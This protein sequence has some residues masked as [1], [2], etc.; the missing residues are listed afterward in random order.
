L[1]AVRMGWGWGQRVGWWGWVR[2]RGSVGMWVVAVDGR[3][4]NLCGCQHTSGRRCR[5]LSLGAVPAHLPRYASAVALDGAWVQFPRLQLLVPNLKP[6]ACLLPLRSTG[7]CRSLGRLCAR[8]G[9]CGPQVR[10]EAARAKDRRCMGSVA[11]GWVGAAGPSVG[12]HGSSASVS[13]L[14]FVP[15]QS[16]TLCMRPS[17]LPDS[18]T[19]TPAS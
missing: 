3:V 8:P 15:I 2:A 12:M 1:G 19:L 10:T 4:T 14:H 13:G 17:R 9:V 16:P 7:R 18:P 11:G 5:L 6:P